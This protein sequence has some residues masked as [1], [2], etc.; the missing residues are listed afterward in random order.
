MRPEVRLL[1]SN[2]GVPVER[3][4]QLSHSV[5]HVVVLTKIL[6]FGTLWMTPRRQRA[7]FSRTTSCAHVAQ[8][9]SPPPPTRDSH[10]N[11]CG[12]K[13][14]DAW[15]CDYL[16]PIPSPRRSSKLR[17]LERRKKGEG[18]KGFAFS[19]SLAKQPFMVF[20]ACSPERSV[21]A[22][23]FCRRR[24]RSLVSFCVPIG[25]C[26]CCCLK[27]FAKLGGKARYL[28]V[29]AAQVVRDVATIVKPQ[30]ESQ[31]IRTRQHCFRLS[32]L[33]VGSIISP[34]NSMV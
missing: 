10:V 23:H 31:R 34:A 14:L 26:A 9:K 24:I 17:C 29:A 7:A 27:S 5:A 33:D 2:K 21:C 1:D 25:G 4:D 22:H 18:G 3:E 16:S 30:T 13:R 8:V 11:G 19:L 6:L 15:A 32:S 20:P 12:C 28:G